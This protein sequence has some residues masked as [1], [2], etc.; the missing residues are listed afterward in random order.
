MEYLKSLALAF[1]LLLAVDAFYLQ[2]IGGYAMR[3]FRIIQ[4]S[5]V[6]FNYV[7]AAVVYA[8]LAYLVTLPSLNTTLKAAAM[9]GAVYA[10]YDFTNLAIFKDY[11]PTFAVMDTLWGATLFA[12][13]RTLHGKLERRLDA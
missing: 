5:P 11:T 2:M 8:A 4:G 10:V 6:V 7:A 1:V 9:G 13:V 12:I 3:M